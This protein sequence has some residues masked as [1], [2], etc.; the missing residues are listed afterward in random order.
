MRGLIIFVSLLV[1]S[2][3]LWSQKPAD[4]PI[5]FPVATI[6]PS[7]AGTPT[8]VQ[9]QG[10]RFATEGTTFLDLFK[11]AYAIHDDQLVGGP[12]WLRSEKFD[13]LADPETETRPSSDQM[14]MAVQ[15][16]LTDRFHLVMHRE[17]RLLP[18][19]LLLRTSEALRL[20][21][22]GADPKGVPGVA[23]SPV[24]RLDVVNSTMGDFASFLQRFVL[25]RPILNE[26]GISGRYDFVLQWTPDT[27]DPNEIENRF[28]GLA[29][30]P[31]VFTAVR[32]Q[33][34]LKLQTAKAKVEVFVVDRVNLPT[35]N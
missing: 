8:A 24:G 2:S 1:W 15:Q 12:A 13:V 28:G 32:D 23:Y 3:L 9:I 33:L 35:A 5:S 27:A 20:T 22:S 29:A 18:V 31:G 4:A 17:K 10:N 7:P 14:K 6:K 21:K 19:Y 26:T 11:Y 34:G 30:P 16:M 25:D